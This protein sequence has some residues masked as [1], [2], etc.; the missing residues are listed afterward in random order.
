MI[1]FDVLNEHLQ[2]ANIEPK[3][4]HIQLD[5]YRPFAVQHGN[6]VYNPWDH[7][8]I[9]NATNNFWANCPGKNPEHEF[10][11]IHTLGCSLQLTN[12]MLSFDVKPESIYYGKRS[13][14]FDLERSY[15]PPNHTIKATV[16]WETN[17]RC[18]IFILA[19][20]HAGMIKS[21]KRYYEKTM[22]INL[23]KKDINT[24][25]TCA[26][27]VLESTFLTNHHIVILKY[28]L[29]LSINVMMIA[30]IMRHIIKIFLYNIMKA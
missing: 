11:V 16:K 28:S 3:Q 29:N 10:L 26:I 19:R 22:A 25:R 14:K 15:C 6:M 27:V 17:N 5:R 7:E 20:S 30:L 4:G 21:Q 1:Q 8:W 9:P 24:T 2:Q 18:Q 12:I 23:T 13:I